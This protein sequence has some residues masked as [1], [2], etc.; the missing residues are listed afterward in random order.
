[1]SLKYSLVF[2]QVGS[3]PSV[4]I[5]K[6]KCCSGVGMSCACA[7]A[8]TAAIAGRGQPDGEPRGDAS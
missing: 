2:D 3:L 4:P 7:L 8:G 5:L 1:M 6:P